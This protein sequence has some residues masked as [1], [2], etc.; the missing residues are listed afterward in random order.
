MLG[1]K[2]LPG[3]GGRDAEEQRD[4]REERDPGAQVDRTADGADQ[5]RPDD[6]AE[7]GDRRDGSD[8][9]TALRRGRS[10]ARRAE[11]SRRRDRDPGSTEREAQEREGQR[12]RLSSQRQPGGR[13]QP[14]RGQQAPVAD[15]QLEPLPQH[16][17]DNHGRGEE[18]RSEAAHGRRRV[19]LRLEK[20]RA[21][22]L[23]PAFDDEGDPAEQP[24]DQKPPGKSETTLRRGPAHFGIPPVHRRRDQHQR[25]DSEQDG[26]RLGPGAPRQAHGDRSHEEP[27]REER[28]GD[29]HHPRAARGLDIGRGDVDDHVD[30][31]GRD[32]DEHQR[33]RELPD[34][35]GEAGQ[36]SRHAEEGEEERHDP[37]PDPVDDPAC[38]EH[39]RQ[40]RDRHREEGDAEL[41]DRCADL[42]LDVRDEDAPRAP[43][44][45]EGREG[46]ERAGGRPHAP[47]RCLAASNSAMPGS[48]A[49]V[50]R[51][52]CCRPAAP[53]TR[54]RRPAGLPA[55]AP[56][57][58]RRRRVRRPCHVS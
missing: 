17:A 41:R 7:V 12:I 47:R 56:C 35:V 53:R 31:P 5:R 51:L 39:R 36:D 13:D 34:G 10:A 26:K 57:P 19:E 46:E 43:K 20:E 2:R 9:A 27:R 18:T 38:Q 29:L 44:R 6:E 37:R 4:A 30:G 28:V 8:R 48:D 32:A 16:P 23:D 42:V 49:H 58:R 52:D 21:P 24:Q 54:R 3:G 25:A 22:V 55:A 40:R 33:E 14:T 1:R 11:E 45:P 15:A 50:Q